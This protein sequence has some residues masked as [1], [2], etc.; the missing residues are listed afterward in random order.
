MLMVGLVLVMAA[1]QLAIFGYVF[2]RIA[3]QTPMILA[4]FTALA[5]AQALLVVVIALWLVTSNAPLTVV[6]GVALHVVALLAL[7]RKR[8]AL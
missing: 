1:M 2:K 4:I 7:R 3:G 8:S 5:A 6:L